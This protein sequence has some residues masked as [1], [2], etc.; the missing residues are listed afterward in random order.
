MNDDIPMGNASFINT[1]FSLSPIE[2]IFFCARQMFGVI[3]QKLNKQTIQII[4][5]KKKR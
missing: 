1:P 5:F 2:S 4:E 3:E